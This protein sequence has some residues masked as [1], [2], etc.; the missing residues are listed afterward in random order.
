M[1]AQQAESDDLHGQA[2]LF[3]IKITHPNAVHAGYELSFVG[4]NQVR[5]E[6]LATIVVESLHDRK[7]RPD[8][9]IYNGVNRFAADFYVFVE[10]KDLSLGL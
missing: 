7:L 2:L 8:S 1:I 3:T 10:S 5:F 6:A 4:K 9:Y